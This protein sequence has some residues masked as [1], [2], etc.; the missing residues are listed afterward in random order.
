LFFPIFWTYLRFPVFFVIPFFLICDIMYC[1]GQNAVA[2][3]LRCG[4]TR[5]LSSHCNCS[6]ML[7]RRL[8][9]PQYCGRISWCSPQFKTFTIMK[10]CLWRNSLKLFDSIF[11]K[12]SSP[13]HLSHSMSLPFLTWT[14]C[15]FK[16]Q[17]SKKIKFYYCITGN[18]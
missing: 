1:C 16:V 12:L 11:H 17:N 4:I 5:D 9:H 7:L 6:P 15:I 14:F 18:K 8:P 10:W 13:C 3:R 2:L